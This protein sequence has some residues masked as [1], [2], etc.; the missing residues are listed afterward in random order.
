M[1]EVITVIAAIHH[2]HLL[3]GSNQDTQAW[4]THT[5]RKMGLDR[6][7]RRPYD[8]RELFPT[9][10]MHSEQLGGFP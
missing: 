9:P 2:T 6:W 1:K 10:F 3:M 4:P 7:Q 8:T 5:S